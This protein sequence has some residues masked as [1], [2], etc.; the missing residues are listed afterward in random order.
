MFTRCSK[1]VPVLS[2]A[3]LRKVLPAGVVLAVLTAS[4]AVIP[5]L[6]STFASC[7]N[8]GLSANPPSPHAAGGVIVLTATAGCGGYAGGTGYSYNASHPQF[9]FWELDPGSR[10]SMVRDYSTVPTFSWNTANLKDGSYNLEVDIKSLDEG[11]TIPYDTVAHLI[12]TIGPTCTAAGLN[13]NPASGTGHTGG[14]I[15]L[16]GSSSSCSSPQYKFWIMD[17]GS[18]WSVV[19]SYSATTTHTWGPVGTFHV[20]QYKLEVDVRD[21]NSTATYDT[22]ANI[23]YNL[24]GCTVAHIVAAPSTGVH[25]AVDITLTASSTCPAGATPNYRFW[26]EDPGSRWSMVQAYGTTAT[27]TWKAA[28]QKAGTTHIEVDV[29]DQ[30]SA[31]DYEATTAASGTVVLT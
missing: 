16:T 9:R 31:D 5:F 3:G 24:V 28:N 1:E 27:Y 30:G 17:P 21:V 20:G 13:A 7:A 23:T 14:S 26:I 2:K 11:S 25:G 29:R 12:Y 18:R 15:T 22:V 10:W 8:A 6:P 19:Q 4:L